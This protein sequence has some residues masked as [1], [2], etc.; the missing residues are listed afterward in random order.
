MP[1]LVPATSVFLPPISLV[2]IEDFAHERNLRRLM[3]Q[4]YLISYEKRESSKK[5]YRALS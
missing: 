2:E 3:L 4:I 5:R 1:A